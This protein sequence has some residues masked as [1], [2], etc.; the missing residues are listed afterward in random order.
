MDENIYNIL[1]LVIPL[2]MAILGFWWSMSTRHAKR[3]DSFKDSNEKQH[4]E[5]YNRIEEINDLSARRHN[6]VRD[7]IEELLK[8]L[9]KTR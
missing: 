9:L 2:I 4:K 7:K 1:A 8:L 5:I 6:H 3:M